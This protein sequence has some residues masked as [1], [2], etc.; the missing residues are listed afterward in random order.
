MNEMNP[1]CNWGA[2]F[3][4][5]WLWGPGCPGWSLKFETV[6][7]GRETHGTW[8]RK[9][10]RWQSPAAIL[11]LQ[12]HPLVREG[13][14]HQQTLDCLKV[15]NKEKLSVGLRWVPDTNTD[16]LADLWL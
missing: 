15:T 14:A 6:K 10:L 13:T 7:Y 4:E 2:L 11:K 16:W 9:Q 8:T 12:T 5:R 3:L 1:V